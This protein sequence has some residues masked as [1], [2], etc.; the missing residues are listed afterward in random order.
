MRMLVA[1]RLA[2]GAH[3]DSVVTEEL[4]ARSIPLAAIGQ[5]NPS[6]QDATQKR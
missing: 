6:A 4:T 3:V 2:A 1:F 5:A